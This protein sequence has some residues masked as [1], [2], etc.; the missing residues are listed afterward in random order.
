MLKKAQV[1]LQNALQDLISNVAEGAKTTDN[2]IRKE[3]PDIRAH[4][5]AEHER[6]RQH[7]TAELLREHKDYR[8]M[9]VDS[10]SFPEINLRK[11]QIKAPHKGTCQ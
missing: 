5:S 8:K 9:F 10:L 11:Q 6:I 7:F 2:L 3:A 4:S 1:D